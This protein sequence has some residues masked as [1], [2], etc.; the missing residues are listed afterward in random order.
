MWIELTLGVAVFST[1]VLVLVG[2]ILGFKSWLMPGGE[3][4]VLVND[5][6]HVP[7]SVGS[8]L[9]LV[10]ANAGLFVPS[11]CGGRGTC[12][13]CRVRVLDG[14]GEILPVERT[15]LTRREAA[16]GERLACQVV[17]K[18]ALRTRL[19]Q[20]VFGARR[21][22]CR[23]RSNAFLS[24]LIKELVLEPPG[25]TAWKHEAGGY[26]QVECPACCIRFSAMKVPES[27]REEW[28]RHGW[29]ELVATIDKATTRA[30]SIASAPAETGA[31]VLNVRLA[32]PPSK[33]RPPA[34]PGQV[35]S[36]LFACEPGDEITITGPF[37]DFHVRPGDA[38]MVF[39]GGGV[40]MAPLRS[41][42]LD[43]LLQERSRRKISYWYG[44]RTL[45][46]LYYAE[47]FERLADAHENF[48]WHVALSD[49]RPEDD[50]R[51]DL[52]F[53][54]AVL[55]DRYIAEHPEPAD[56]EY[57]VCG[58]PAMTAAVMH[59]LEENGVEREQVFYDDFGA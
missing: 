56:C 21:Y 29:S 36:F 38:E 52:G 23:V 19:P 7:A 40:G 11:A 9:L 25:D 26:L 45:G 30:Y 39:V 42:I 13:Q 49:P 15:H 28:R 51:G 44:A 54:H 12:G 18:R 50:W 22:R 59:M 3:V 47:E 48:S 55:H 46:D 33:V 27:Y 8:K 17:V 24:P 10:L 31:L 58:P 37:G 35:S 2:V 4:D 1:V 20:E 43:Q 32:L 53:I 34:P 16:A 6:R 57:Y 5:T 41:M 14:G